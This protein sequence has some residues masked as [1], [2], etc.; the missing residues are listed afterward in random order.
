MADVAVQ[1]PEAPERV[2]S[3]G[4]IFG[5]L[6]S[7]KETFESIVRRPTWVLPVIIST[8]LAICVVALFTH[9]GGWPSFFEK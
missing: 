8:V 2:N 1:A 6:F 5:V 9:R 4:R 7:P 3:I